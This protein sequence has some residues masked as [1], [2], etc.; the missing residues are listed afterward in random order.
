MSP[1]GWTTAFLTIAV[2]MV[3]ALPIFAIVRPRALESDR[4]SESSDQ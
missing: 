3:L 2:L 4:A 1:A